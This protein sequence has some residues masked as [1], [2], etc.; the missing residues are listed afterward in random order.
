MFITSGTPDPKTLY[1]QNNT[2]QFCIISST[3]C[4]KMLGVQWSIGHVYYLQRFPSQDGLSPY[5]HLILTCITS[6]IPCPITHC[7]QYST[8]QLYVFIQALQFPWKQ[9]LPWRWR[10]YIS[11]NLH[12]PSPHRITTQKNITVI[13][14]AVRTSNVA[15]QVTIMYIKLGHSR[16]HNS[17]MCR[18]ASH[19]QVDYLKHSRSRTLHAQE[20]NFQ[21]RILRQVCQVP[22]LNLSRAALYKYLFYLRHSMFQDTCPKEHL[23]AVET[24]CAGKCHRYHVLPQA[25]QTPICHV[26]KGASYIHMLLQAFQTYMSIWWSH[27]F[28]LPHVLQTPICLHIK[29]GCVTSGTP[30][31]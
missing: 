6:G 12:P 5:Y 18:G 9:L 8:L 30:E 27:L 7:N 14:T 4:P 25:V 28:V 17:F 1:V 15:K 21:L 10:Q 20:S 11:P 29:C 2:I 22:R 16:S 19:S 26:S 13:F 24:L 23:L 3:P 31:S